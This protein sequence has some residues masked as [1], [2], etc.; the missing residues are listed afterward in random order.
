[1]GNKWN[2]LP[3][4]PR[5]LNTKANMDLLFLNVI[6]M[7]SLIS[8]QIPHDVNALARTKKERQTKETE[9]VSDWLFD[10]LILNTQGLKCRLR[11]QYMY[12]AKL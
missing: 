3:E 8:G 10:W 6:H 11:L 2:S 5:E 1:M 7:A 9:T 12:A 4:T